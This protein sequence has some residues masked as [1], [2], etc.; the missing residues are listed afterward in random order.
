MPDDTKKPEP[1]MRTIFLIIL[2]LLLVYSPIHAADKWDKMD[3]SLL[4]AS[5][6]LK[7]IDWQQTRYIANNPDR[8]YE[9]NPILGK[10]PSETEV[11]LYFVASYAGQ[12]IIAHYLPSKYRKCWLGLWIGMSG[13]NSIHNNS[14]GIKMQW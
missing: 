13:R 9:Q 2:I 8:F 10:H 14:I 12:V 4:A 1:R 7:V 3:Y 6:V 5:S 11:N